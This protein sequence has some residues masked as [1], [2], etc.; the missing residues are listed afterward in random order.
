M[1]K[2]QAGMLDSDGAE[3]AEQKLRAMVDG[4]VA[5]VNER[6]WVLRHV[7]VLLGME[8][9]AAA[10][11]AEERAEAVA[12]WRRLIELLATVG[13][14]VLVF[15]DLHWADNALLDFVDHLAEWV[16]DVPLLIVC[17]ARPELLERRRDWGGGKSNAAT[18]ALEPLTDGDTARLLVALMQRA[19][20]PADTQAALLERAQGNPLYAEEYVRMLEDGGMVDR[21]GDAPLPESVQGII[22]ARLDTLPVEEKQLLQNA[23][24]IG[25]VAWLGAIL[26]L[27]GGERSAAEERLHRLVRKEFLRRAQRSSVEGDT[28]YVFR[29]A[30][31][32]DVAYQ[33][34]ARAAGPRSTSG[35]PAGWSSWPPTATRRCR[36]APTTTVRRWTMPRRRASRA[37]SW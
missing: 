19:V 24:V 28:E 22:A 15:E 16:T 3:L 7:R 11:G 32:R 34:I 17:T 1:L 36:C 6:A 4:V 23:A 8:A 21:A 35:Q 29:H 37:S 25:K 10:G 2:S 18:V 33:Q 26:E 31:V 9:A 30:L 5:D 13:P 12:A 20:I 14:M 27:G